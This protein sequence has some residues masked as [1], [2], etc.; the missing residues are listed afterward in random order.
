M[1]SCMILCMTLYMILYMMGCDDMYDDKN[2]SH[3]IIDNND[4]RGDRSVQILIN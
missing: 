4:L 2:G 3:S 1:M